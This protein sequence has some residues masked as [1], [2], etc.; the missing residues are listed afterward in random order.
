MILTIYK[1]YVNMKSVTTKTNKKSEQTTM[2]QESGPQLPAS[3]NHN[4]LKALGRRI[5]GAFGGRASKTETPSINVAARL[6]PYQLGDTDIVAPDKSVFSLPD[7]ANLTRRLETGERV[8]L[9]QQGPR[10][11]P[12]IVANGQGQ[13]ADAESGT[14]DRPAA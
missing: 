5:L 11:V 1:A 4:V 12:E 8:H 2:S 7:T 3:P 14:I 10:S 9:L 13:P 6:A